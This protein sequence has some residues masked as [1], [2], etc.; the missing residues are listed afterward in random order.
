MSTVIN[1]DDKTLTIIVTPKATTTVCETSPGGIHKN[2]ATI[3][4]NL[5]EIGIVVPYSDTHFPFF[6]C[7]DFEAYFSKDQLSTIAPC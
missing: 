2:P 5:E 3:F 6:A 7:C 1:C 4:Q